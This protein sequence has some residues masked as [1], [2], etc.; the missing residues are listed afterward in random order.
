[1]E[2]TQTATTTEYLVGG[3]GLS[4]GEVLRVE[5][6]RRLLVYVPQGRVWITEEGGLDDTVLGAGEW[7][8][9]DRP[10]VAVVEAWTPSVV[11]LTSPHEAGY[12]KRVEV[13]PRPALPGSVRDRIRI[14][15]RRVL[16]AARGLVQAVWRELAPRA[17]QFRAPY[18]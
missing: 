4:A 12:A 1:M 9:L 3:H 17:P 6:A 15:G 10:G 18:F 8:R 11:L 14:R 16:A 7:F 2:T 5:D 13:C